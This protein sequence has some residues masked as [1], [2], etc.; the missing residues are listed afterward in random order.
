MQYCF[1]WV[2]QQAI[3]VNPGDYFTSSIVSQ[4]G[5][6][7]DSEGRDTYQLNGMLLAEKRVAGFGR[8]KVYSLESLPAG[9]SALEAAPS[10]CHLD[11]TQV[12]DIAFKIETN[13]ML[14]QG[15]L[16]RYISLMVT[17]NG[18]RREIPLCSPVVSVDWQSRGVYLVKVAGL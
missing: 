8:D 5:I 4:N 17:N 11:P 1:E 7:N 9:L 12:S 13:M 6:L 2:A 16:S 15:L 18:E 14:D 10:T 3:D